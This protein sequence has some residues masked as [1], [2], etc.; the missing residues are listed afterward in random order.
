MVASIHNDKPDVTIQPA[1]WKHNFET[2]VGLKILYDPNDAY[3]VWSHLRHGL[4]P[5]GNF[6]NNEKYNKTLCFGDKIGSFH[7]AENKVN[8]Y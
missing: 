5:L 3:H 1:I 7:Q 2:T 4:C 6:K 8:P